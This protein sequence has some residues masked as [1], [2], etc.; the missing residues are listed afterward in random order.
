[1]S[2]T[3][4]TL[5][6]A[7]AFSAAALAADPAAPATPAV[8]TPAPVV[9][10]NLAK[11]VSYR[12]KVMKAASDHLAAAGILAK[13]E[14]D[15]PQDMIMHATALLELS[16]TIGSLYPAGTGPDAVKTEAKKEV[17]TQPDKFAAA[18]KAL[19]TESLGLVDAAKKN[20]IAAYKAQVGKIGE[21]CGGCHD[22]FRVEDER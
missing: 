7:L 18:A 10:L 2:R 13:G 15:R 3:A 6:L 20:D 12:H 19:E 22:T 5:F 21:A 17:W 1:M 14:V 16:A 9:P 4:S 8:V 11:T